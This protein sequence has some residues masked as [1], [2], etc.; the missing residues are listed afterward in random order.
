[1]EA[2]DKFDKALKYLDI[3]IFFY[4]Y[5]ALF[6]YEKALIYTKLGDYSKAFSCVET[7]YKKD[8]LSLRVVYLYSLLLFKRGRV[9]EALN[10]IYKTLSKVTPAYYHINRWVSKLELLARYIS[11][12]N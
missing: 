5:E 4:P 11:G 7:A 9:D 10:L 1:M 12:K 8:P 6:Y 2:H 3:G